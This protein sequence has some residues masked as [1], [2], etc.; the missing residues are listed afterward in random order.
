MAAATGSVAL[1]LPA[2]VVYGMGTATGLMARYAGAD[3]ASPPGADG[4]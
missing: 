4:P 2:L 3:L 1:L